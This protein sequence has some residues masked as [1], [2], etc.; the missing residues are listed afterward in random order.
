ME[1][2]E[3]E[4]LIELRTYCRNVLN[5]SPSMIK[6]VEERENYEQKIKL[7]TKKLKQLE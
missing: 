5:H 6:S 7:I 3:R 4:R 2:T 1:K